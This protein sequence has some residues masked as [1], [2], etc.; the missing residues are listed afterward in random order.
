[1]DFIVCAYGEPG[2]EKFMPYV[3]NHVAGVE[4]QNYDRKG[5]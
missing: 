5:V 3:E 1:M 2:E 4:L